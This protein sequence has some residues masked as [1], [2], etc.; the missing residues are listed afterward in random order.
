MCCHLTLLLDGGKVPSSSLPPSSIVLLVICIW[1]YSVLSPFLSA[2]SSFC[3]LRITNTQVDGTFFAERVVEADLLAEANALHIEGRLFADTIV[4]VFF[5]AASLHCIWIMITTF[6]FFMINFGED[7]QFCQ[8]L[9]RF[10][11]KLYPGVFRN[12]LYPNF[13]QILSYFIWI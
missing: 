5:I 13:I 7:D 11:P 10:Y 2:F 9:S 3:T 6:V 4:V 12:I 1:C 8:I